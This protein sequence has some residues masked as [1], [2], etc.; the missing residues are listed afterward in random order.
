MNLSKLGSADVKSN[1]LSYVDS[2]SRDAREIFEHFK[3]AEFI[4]Q[5]DFVNEPSEIMEAF[6]ECYE[7]AKLP[8]VSD[9]NLIWELYE[10]LRAAEVFLWSE[11]TQ[12]SEVFFLK[13]KSNAAISNVCRPAVDRWHHRYQAARSEFEKH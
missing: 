3:F 12:F 11:V 4:A 7:T 13:S 6:Q 1:L 2:F 8:D 9:P 5:L 10:K